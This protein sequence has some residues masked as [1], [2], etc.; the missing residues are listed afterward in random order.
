MGCSDVIGAERPSVP[1]PLDR[2]LRRS[3]AAALALAAIGFAGNAFGQGF[4][5][6]GTVIQGKASITTARATTNIEARS[7]QVV[8]N[9]T[10][11]ES[12]PLPGPDCFYIFLPING[13]ANYSGAGAAAHGYTVLNRVLLPR[14][15]AFYGSVRSTLGENPGGNIW[16][17]SP[18]GLY[19]GPT[20]KFDVGSLVLTSQDIDTRGGLFGEGGEIRFRGSP[21]SAAYIQIAPGAS[22]SALGQGAYV[23]LVAPRIVQGGTIHANGSVALVAAEHADIMINAGMLDIVITQGTG[24][25]NG[26]VHTGSTGGS[27]TGLPQTVSMVAVAKND[28]MTMLLSGT[29]GYRPAAGVTIDGGAVILSASGAGPQ[30]T[31]S[32]SIGNASFASP[33]DGLAS[34]AIAIAPTRGTVNFQRDATFAAGEAID[35][36]AQGETTINATGSLNLNAG[37]AASPGSVTLVASGPSGNSRTSGRI[38]VGSALAI[39]AS[40]QTETGSTSGGTVAVLADGG[41]IAADRLTATASGYGSIAQGRGGSIL[42]S[43]S[44]RGTIATSALEAAADGIGGSSGNGFG[45]TIALA[46]AGGA[47]ELGTVR[48]TARGFA[49][50]VATE[51]A[52]ASGGSVTVELLSRPQSWTTLDIDASAVGTTQ[53]APSPRLVGGTIGIAVAS[54]A[55]LSL[56][57]DLVGRA[58]GNASPGGPGIDIRA[59][60]PI[61]VGGTALLNSVGAVDVQLGDAPFQIAKTLTIS[62]A[63]E[64]DTSGSIAVGGEARLSAAKGIGLGAIE[65]DTVA[66][67]AGGGIVIDGP[68]AAR[69]A[70]R[71]EAADSVVLN[72]VVDGATIFVESADLDFGSGGQLGERGRT[73]SIT[74]SNARPAN[75]IVIGGTDSGQADTYSLAN[76][77]LGRLFADQAVA[78]GSE[79]PGSP[80]GEMV[81]RDLDLRFGDTGNIGAGGTLKLQTAGKLT[82]VGKANLAVTGP[83]D[84]VIFDAATIDVDLEQGAIALRDSGGVGQGRLNLVAD[85]IV[86]AAP[87]ARALIDA[88]ASPANINLLLDRPAGSTP[89]EFFEAGT[90]DVAVEDGFFVQNS[91]SG[92]SFAAR[93][94]FVAN[95]LNISTGTS[96]A[97][98]IVNGAILGSGGAVFRGLETVGAVTINAKPAGQASGVDPSSSINGCAI[99]ANCLRAPASAGFSQ[100]GLEGLLNI[101]GGLPGDGRLR[102]REAFSEEGG[103]SL[104]DRNDVLDEIDLLAGTT[105]HS[106]AVPTNLQPLPYLLMFEPRDP[107]A[108]RPLLDDPV[109]G[110]GN[111]D[112]WQNG[113][114]GTTNCTP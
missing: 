81:V 16:F 33:V 78:I 4:A 50:G 29:M 113:C 24:D 34:G 109:T 35:L 32:I 108:F 79:P 85:R 13:S 74:L 25:A 14:R 80:V 101:R 99:T 48:M 61:A 87:D 88:K 44:N 41:I 15:A 55:S 77:D 96:D 106:F 97:L 73:Q 21:D 111:D 102:T 54:G 37:N 52:N 98:V 17:S 3:T 7:R 8:I 58:D 112:L 28:A 63:G 22:I 75:A 18:T 36:S 72:D 92:T 57:G 83:E 65:G 43:A 5:A 89:R 47:L 93:R 49:G 114:S 76:A 30:A 2:R 94:G 82:V 10:I 27:V 46:D 105:D 90:I 62:T 70:L 91:G 20:A 6:T 40:G 84:A 42:V 1:A 71:L 23:A 26:I 31:G 45:G 86:A 67:N 68:L 39:N 64:L 100:S 69:A 59:A 103:I 12:A 66:L 53:T 60:G 104:L 19:V 110:V 56:D 107:A 51:P 95:R 9:W 11:D 38:D